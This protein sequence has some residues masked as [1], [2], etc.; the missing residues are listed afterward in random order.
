VDEWIEPQEYYRRGGAE[1]VRLSHGFCP[2]CYR[3][4]LHQDDD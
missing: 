1:V 4:K 3:R 2:E